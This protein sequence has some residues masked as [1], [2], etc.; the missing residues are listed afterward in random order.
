MKIWTKKSPSF[1]SRRWMEALPLG[2]GITSAMLF[3]SVGT[4]CININRFDRWEGGDADFLPDVSEDFR[5]I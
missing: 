3:G 2:N 4:E 5:K 1:P